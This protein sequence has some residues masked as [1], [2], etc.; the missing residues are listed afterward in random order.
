MKTAV[1]SSD[2]NKSLELLL[3]LAKKLGIKTKVLTDEQIEEAGLTTAIKH[4]RTGKFVDT[5]KF[6][7]ELK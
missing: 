2:S 7:K 6:L 5:N 1:L 4:G 3:E